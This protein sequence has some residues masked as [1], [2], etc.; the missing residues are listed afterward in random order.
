M[1]MDMTIQKFSNLLSILFLPLEMCNGCPEELVLSD[2]AVM[3]P[4]DAKL[5]VFV[6]TNRLEKLPIKM[7]LNIL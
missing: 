3:C 5:L 1:D 6:R 7:C 4:A 2:S